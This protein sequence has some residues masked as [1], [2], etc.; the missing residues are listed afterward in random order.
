MREDNIILGELS[1]ERD[2]VV[3]NEQCLEAGIGTLNYMAPEIIKDYIN[4][5]R[6][7]YNHLYYYSYSDCILIPNIIIPEI[8]LYTLLYMYCILY[9]IRY[10][11]VSYQSHQITFVALHRCLRSRS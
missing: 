2:P 11:Y 10:M 3:M 9:Y 4:Y 7:I 6:K 8:I 5:S 1:L